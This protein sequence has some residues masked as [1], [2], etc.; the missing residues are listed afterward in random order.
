M[1]LPVEH[2]DPP[3]T[4]MPPAGAPPKFWNYNANQ[5]DHNIMTEPYQDDKTFQY[6]LFSPPNFNNG[7]TYATR[8]KSIVGCLYALLKFTKEKLP[9]LRWWLDSGTLIGAYRGG[10][11]IP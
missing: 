7:Y 9:N 8:R 6:W 1:R 10:R 11:Y 4:Y 2:V 3:D 5:G